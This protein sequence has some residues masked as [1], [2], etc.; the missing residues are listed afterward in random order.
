MLAGSG[1][2]V[3][4]KRRALDKLMR[5]QLPDPETCLLPIIRCALAGKASG[6]SIAELSQGGLEIN[7]TGALG[8]ERLEDPYSALFETRTAANA[9]A[10]H[11]ATGLLCALRLNRK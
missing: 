3:V 2:F 4:D 6:V 8:R 10:R 5:F 1:T 7:S 11:L 9:A